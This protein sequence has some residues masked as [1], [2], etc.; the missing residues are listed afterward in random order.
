MLRRLFLCDD[1]V[2]STL[3]SCPSKDM[4]AFLTSARPFI[5]L[6]KASASV[7]AAHPTN[8]LSIMIAMLSVLMT[9]GIVLGEVLL[10]FWKR[11]VV[12]CE[13][14]QEVRVRG[15]FSQKKI[16]EKSGLRDLP[17]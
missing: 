7:R 4:L 14:E 10:G 2:V 13:G 5:C 11:V 6:Q 8:T 3:I 1:S 12:L 9:V 15:G 16:S 17:P